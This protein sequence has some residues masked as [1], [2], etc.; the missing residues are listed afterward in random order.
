[1]ENQA[2]L[3]INSIDNSLSLTQQLF[4]M[5]IFLSITSDPE[6]QEE[7]KCGLYH[8]FYFSIL[9]ERPLVSRKEPVIEN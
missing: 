3:L 4:L 2:L 9:N 7:I 5:F 6:G 1:M 8:C